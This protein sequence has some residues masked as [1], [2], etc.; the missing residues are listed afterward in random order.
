MTT[1]TAQAGHEVFCERAFEAMKKDDSQQRETLGLPV[2]VYAFNC[3][4]PANH[5]TTESVRDLII[6]WVAGLQETWSDRQ[7]RYIVDHPNLLTIRIG[8]QQ[9]I[10]IARP[11]KWHIKSECPRGDRDVT[12]HASVDTREGMTVI[13][14]EWDW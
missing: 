7:Q 5:P 9:V 11:I 1:I 4:D 12:G 2:P 8:Y 6:D 10:T 14:V 13:D 3:F